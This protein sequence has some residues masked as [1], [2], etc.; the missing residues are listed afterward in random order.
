MSESS[1][2]EPEFTQATCVTLQLK[3]KLRGHFTGVREHLLKNLR[4]FLVDYECY[5]FEGKILECE[6]VDL[7]D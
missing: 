3:F 2:D 7:G 6:V 5:E 1:G 4:T